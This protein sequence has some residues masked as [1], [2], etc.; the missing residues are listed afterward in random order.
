MGADRAG[1]KAALPT[2]AR[3]PVILG[4]HYIDRGG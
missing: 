1:E 2:S 4:E 3:R